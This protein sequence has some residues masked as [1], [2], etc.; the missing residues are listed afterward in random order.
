MTREQ[1]S[2]SPRQVRPSRRTAPS[3][4]A[5]AEF[6]EYLSPAR[7]SSPEEPSGLQLGDRSAPVRTAI[8]AAM[9]TFTAVATAA[10]RPGSLLVTAAPL[11]AEPLTTVLRDDPVGERIAHLIERRVSLYVL[12]NSFAAAPGGFDDSMAERLGLAGTTVLRPT[13]YEKLFKVAVYTPPNAVEA[14]MQAAAEAGA[15]HI[16]NYSHCSFQVSGTGTFLPHE[17]ARPAIGSVGQLE[18]TPE[19]R[20]EMV[21]QE[22]ELRDVIAAILDAHPYEEVAYDVYALDN[23]GTPYG[24]GRVADLPLDVS[25]ETILHQIQDAFP[26]SSIRCSHRTQLAIS[27]VAVVSGTSGDLVAAASAVRVGAFVTGH[28]TPR[29]WMIAENTAMVLVEVGY[30]SSVAP[31]L[32][33]LCTQIRKTFGPEGVEVIC[34]T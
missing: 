32:Q 1:E 18:R 31:G 33:R 13:A 29:D 16:G 11:I 3:V 12:P 24:R 22:R 19:V 7:L 9:P 21:T 25:L 17:G 14:V 20:L 5:V 23:P 2:G 26:G 10:A 34:C 6:L 27:R 28:A 15:G 30:A 4:A 8:V